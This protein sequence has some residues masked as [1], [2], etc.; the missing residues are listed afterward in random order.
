MM[1]GMSDAHEM[2]VTEIIQ[3]VKVRENSEW[4]KRKMN[5]L[6]EEE[7]NKN[8]FSDNEQTFSEHIFIP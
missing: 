1:L 6:L 7:L 5:V 4:P 2:Y 3:T 8:R